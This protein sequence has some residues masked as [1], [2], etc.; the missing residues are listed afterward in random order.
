MFRF[1]D[2]AFPALRAF[3]RTRGRHHTSQR[4][5]RTLSYFP[6]NSRSRLAVF[7]YTL[8]PPTA[9]SRCRRRINGSRRFTCVDVGEDSTALDIALRYCYPVRKPK[10]KDIAVVDRVLAAGLKY[11]IDV[12]VES[13]QSLLVSKPVMANQPIR[14]Y[15]I[16]C[17]HNLRAPARAAA[18]ATLAH[19][20]F[21]FNGKELDE[22]SA[23]PL[24]R[25]FH[26]RKRVATR[27]CDIFDETSSCRGTLRTGA[28]DIQQSFLSLLL[29]QSCVQRPCNEG[30]GNPAKFWVH[31][32]TRAVPL[33]SEIP[34]TDAIFEDKFLQPISDVIREC[35]R[36]RDS[37]EV[38]MWCKNLECRIR[39]V[40]DG[41]ADSASVLTKLS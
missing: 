21:E 35:E 16:A 27:I 40:Y 3:R 37:H 34:H 17:K 19:P 11:E 20:I 33:I 36:C 30:C 14:A 41:V 9:S 8:Q 39:H 31:Y 13:M 38:L 18:K 12:V 2:G 4:R 7:P 32:A 28:E 24:L 25:L 15:L 6:C 29:R 10:I 1:H 5:R 22:V 23:R 26:Y